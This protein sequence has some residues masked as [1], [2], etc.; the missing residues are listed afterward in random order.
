LRYG[1]R[2]RLRQASPGA[3][4]VPTVF[5]G[6]YATLGWSISSQHFVHPQDRSV[7]PEIAGSEDLRGI[8]AMAAGQSAA[9]PPR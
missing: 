5:V 4:Y 9:V 2:V 3:P 1:S 7:I 6:M 8:L